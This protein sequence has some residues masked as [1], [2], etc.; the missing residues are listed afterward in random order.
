VGSRVRI[1]TVRS[2][3]ALAL[4]LIPTL[5]ACEIGSPDDGGVSATDP[6]TSEAEASDDFGQTSGLEPA[7]STLDS[8]TAPEP[9]TAD[10]TAGGDATQGDGTETS[11]TGVDEQPQPPTNGAELLP[12]L[13]AGEYLGW[14]AESGVHPSSGPHGGGVRTFVNDVLHASLAA[15]SAS[16]PQGA[17]AIKELYGDGAT[18]IGWAVEVK[19]QADSAG[20]DGWYWYERFQDSVYAD[21]TGEG[22]CTGCHG[23]GNDYV[24]SPFPLQ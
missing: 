14:T 7:T 15:G 19:L 5:P 2:A 22:I 6:S 4:T 24:L 18:V 13:E 12:W 21:G 17:A 9:T 23:G 20:G 10:S 1:V 3:I 16:H 11:T 8:T